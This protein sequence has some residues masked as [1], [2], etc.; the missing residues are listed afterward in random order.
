[1]FGIIYEY[2]EVCTGRSAYIGKASSYY[3]HEHALNARHKIHLKARAPIPFD[4]VLRDKP[5]AFLLRII[6]TVVCGSSLALRVALCP[7]EK[8]RI[9]V[10]QPKFNSI[11]FAALGR[12]S[13]KR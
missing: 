8:E 7:L 6:D 11:R 3:G 1:M 4:L 5:D 13:A 12:V 9:R 10:R 2:V